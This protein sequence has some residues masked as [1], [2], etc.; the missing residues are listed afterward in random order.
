MGIKFVPRGVI[1]QRADFPP[2]AC[3]RISTGACIMGKNST[4]QSCLSCGK[5]EGMHRRRYCSLTCRQRLQFQ[6]NIRTGLLKALNTRYATFYFTRHRIIMDVLPYHSTVLFSFVS[7]RTPG[8]T[9]ADDF[10]RMSNHLGDIWWKEKKRTE[11]RYLASR[12]VLSSAEAA[13]AAG[14]DMDP[15]ATL[16]PAVNQ[17]FLACLQLEKAALTSENALQYIKSAYRCQA[18]RHHP[19]KGGSAAYFRKIHDAYRQLVAWS[20]DPKFRRQVGF[21][22]KWFYEGARNRWIRPA[23]VRGMRK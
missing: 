6:L 9:P 19:D 14:G 13:H 4:G 15:A 5:R 8:M 12:H 18:M 21:D 17:K 1:R 20:E 22:D 11:K 16:I 7:V 2:A 10:I 23:P 3:R